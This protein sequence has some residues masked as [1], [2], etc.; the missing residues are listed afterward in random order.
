MQPL[1]FS[2]RLK[3]FTV[4]YYSTG[5]PSRFLSLVEVTDPETGEMFDQTK[6][7][8]RCATRA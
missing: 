4:D 1:P 6:K 7:M 5:M 8:S 2:L 3:K